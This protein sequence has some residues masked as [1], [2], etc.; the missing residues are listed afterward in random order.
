[1]KIREVII[2]VGLGTNIGKG[3]GAAARGSGMAAGAAVYGAQ[4]TI[5]YGKQAVKG[6]VDNVK[7]GFNKG[8]DTVDKLFDPK[9][10]GEK[11]TSQTTDTKDSDFENSLRNA[12]QG[13]VYDATDKS[14]LKSL[15]TSINSGEITSP[16]RQN[17]IAALKAAYLGLPLDDVQ[18]KSIT[19]IRQRI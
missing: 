15:Y 11:G 6:T 4:K 3:A 1:M 19:A 7:K 16:D 8:Y 9:R 14:S 13:Q 5:D 18:R 17:E 12:E 10:W 2:E